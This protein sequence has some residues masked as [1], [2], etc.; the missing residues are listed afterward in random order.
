MI[1]TDLPTDIIV[2]LFPY[3]SAQDFLALTCS[4]KALLSFRQEPTFWRKK[5]IST[6]RIPPQP[7]LADD[8]PRWQWLYK[9]LFSQTHIFT[10]GNNE[11][12]NLGHGFIHFSNEVPYGG[13]PAYERR[14]G[15]P[16]EVEITNPIGIVVDVQCG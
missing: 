2:L 11:K 16:S 6:F 4:T 7:L 5:T 10:W 8:G 13:G 12:L 3:L 1:L 9:S 15:W 14:V